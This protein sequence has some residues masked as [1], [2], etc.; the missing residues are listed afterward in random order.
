MNTLL[1]D[2]DSSTIDTLNTHLKRYNNIHQNTRSAPGLS[3]IL[4]AYSTAV[5]KGV[6]AL[7]V[8]EMGLALNVVLNSLDTIKVEA[9]LD[10]VEMIFY[11]APM[12]PKTGLKLYPVTLFP[13]FQTAVRSMGL[14][15]GI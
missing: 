15:Y 11:Y 1:E 7:S 2:I 13:I 12:Y 4:E 8:P 10:T 6:G 9:I 3:Y 14:Y 5:P